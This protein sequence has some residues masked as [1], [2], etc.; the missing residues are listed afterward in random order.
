ML[1]ANETADDLRL[2][3]HL[4]GKVAHG[5]AKEVSLGQPWDRPSTPF[6]LVLQTP[7]DGEVSARSRHDEWG[8]ETARFIFDTGRA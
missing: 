3:L 8:I 4:F 5:W 2:L 1:L 7:P 6:H